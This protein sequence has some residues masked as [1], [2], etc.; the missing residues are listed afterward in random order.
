[1]AWVLMMTAPVLALAEDNVVVLVAAEVAVVADS[2]DVGK[3]WKV[4][5]SFQPRMDHCLK[6][7]KDVV[8]VVGPEK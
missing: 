8:E 3:P 1:M 4:W 2:A 5:D 6:V 7:M